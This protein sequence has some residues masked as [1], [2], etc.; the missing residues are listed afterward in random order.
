V[1]PGELR[2]AL[3]AGIGVLVV[4][5]IPFGVWG[6]RTIQKISDDLRKVSQS[7]YGVA[8]DNGMRGQLREVEGRVSE[9]A[10][11]LADYAIVLDRHTGRLTGHDRDLAALAQHRMTE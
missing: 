7:V 3:E 11:R 1:L 5:G 4:V 9:H 8:G 2:A 6:I 10:S